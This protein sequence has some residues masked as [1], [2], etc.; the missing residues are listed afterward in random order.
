MGNI[1]ADAIE[2][3]LMILL[4]GG[5]GFIGSAFVHSWL[6]AQRGPLLVLDALTYAGNLHNL[7]RLQGLL[8][9]V[10]GSVCDA[11]LVRA[12]L[13]EHRPRAVIHMADESH[14]DRSIAAPGAYV[15]TNVEGGFVLL[16]AA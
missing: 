6:A 12:L 11:P 5:A 9:F 8:H 10:H 13:A 2:R 1:L 4:T 7:A 16:R 3:S 14:V 15:R